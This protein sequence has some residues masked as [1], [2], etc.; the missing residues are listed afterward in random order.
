MVGW[1]VVNRM[2][3]HR[4]S[5]VSSVWSHNNYAH[6]YPGTFISR[7][8]AEDILAGKARDI[9]QGATHFYSPRSMP[10]EGDTHL[11]GT[12]IGGGLEEVPG[13]TGPHGRAVRNYRP[14]WVKYY[15]SIRIPQIKE[16]EFKFYRE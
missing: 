8:I 12:D 7:R 4:Y 11:S 15:H 3:R 10:K 5:A 1:T 2:K 14:G 6:T 13:V 9:S 16:N